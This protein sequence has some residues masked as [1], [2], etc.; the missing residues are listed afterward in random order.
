LANMIF[1]SF[2][3]AV[4]IA[5]SSMFMN[6]SYEIEAFL[7]GLLLFLLS[8]L[9]WKFDNEMP[10]LCRWFLI[11]MSVIVTF[12]TTLWIGEPSLIIFMTIPIVFAA[13]F[14]N[15]RAALIIS[16]GVSL[17]L[18]LMPPIDNIHKE[19]LVNT[20]FL[21]WAFLGTIWLVC[22][23]I[24]GVANWCWEY[25]QSA[26]KSFEESRSQRSDYEQ[27]IDDLTYANRQLALAS[28]RIS[29]LRSI[30]EESR[31]AKTR[32]VS[33]VSHEFRTP[34]NMIVGMI[35]LI[36]DAPENYNVNFS[37]RLQED[38]KVI[39]RNSKHLANMINDVLD[40]VRIDDGHL[41]LHR[42][43]ADIACLIKSATEAVRPLIRNKQLSLQISLVD[44]LPLVYC[45]PIRIEQ[46]IL[47]LMSNAA[48]CTR[49]GEIKIDA[50]NNEDNIIVGVH[51]TGPGIAIE[52]RKWIYEP[53]YQGTGDNWHNKRG[54]GL[55][56]TISKRIVE[57][58]GGEIWFESEI[59]VGTS[60]Y[61][62]IPISP[63]IEH[64][65]KPGYKIKG[66]WVWHERKSVYKPSNNHYRPRIIL[67]D[68][69]KGFKS[70]LKDR[71][72]EVEIIEASDLSQIRNE[73]Q[74]NI[75]HAVVIN[76]HG[77]ESADQILRDFKQDIE[78]T[79]LFLCSFPR[80]IAQAVEAGAQGHLT[81]PV[82]R[83]D[84]QELIQSVHTPVKKVLVVDDDKEVLE[85]FCRMLHAYDS[86][87]CVIM[88][89]N[90]HEA[91][92][93]LCHENPDIMLLDIVMPDSDGWMVLEYV[94][95]MK[96]DNSVPIF[97]ISAQDSYTQS[98][99]SDFIL[100]AVDEGF[101]SDKFL[102][103]IV[104]LSNLS[105]NHT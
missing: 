2:I 27:T 75:A 78:G 55:G 9:A 57:L 79:P 103:C 80:S 46:V 43:R 62:K 100:V 63:P 39:Y 26:R 10:N 61:F 102:Q 48:R 14:I 31:E 83:E 1:L 50:S 60:F 28:K 81:K 70:V 8:V 41:T 76:T 53:F 11:I 104:V 34:L 96:S 30:A 16:T 12:R 15:L 69:T 105:V 18:I 32:F 84:I 98:N 82:I 74:K 54:S 58:H 24:N 52:H 38:L 99:M 29:A 88:A 97:T 72:N 77:L 65:A 37:P 3:G 45:D 89:S 93:K 44:D 21:I 6:K 35:E 66:D 90:G 17:S 23:R 94:S 71:A 42:E 36:L 22:N 59:E 91:L 5:A 13:L 49:E 4:L 101:T 20:V 92:D 85:L 68:Q 7:V 87:M 33:R 73:L 95:R 40:L 51:D 25:Y 19:L 67:F 47:N 64:I 56:L 86:E